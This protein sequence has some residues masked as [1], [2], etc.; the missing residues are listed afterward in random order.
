MKFVNLKTNGSKSVRNA[1][2]IG[3]LNPLDVVTTGDQ[4]V[5]TI[6]DSRELSPAP[7]TRRM[8]L[9]GSKEEVKTFLETVLAELS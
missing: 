8:V 1:E 4:V 3:T 6:H 2:V 7:Q 9:T 5:V